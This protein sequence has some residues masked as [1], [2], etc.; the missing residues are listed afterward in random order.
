MTY[1]PTTPTGGTASNK[2]GATAAPFPPVKQLMQLTSIGVSYRLWPD[3]LVKAR[4][5]GEMYSQDD[6][7]T[8]N[9]MPATAVPAA[10]AR[11]RRAGWGA[12]WPGDG[13]QGRG[14]EGA[15][16]VDVGFAPEGWRL[17]FHDPLSE[18]L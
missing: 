1:N 8:D 14:R 4:V 6:Y 15:E 17:T 2:L 10:P 11:G 7:R 5:N 13:A 9:V 3:W 18:C 12:S 16:G